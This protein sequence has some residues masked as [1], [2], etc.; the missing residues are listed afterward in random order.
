MKSMTQPVAGYQPN[1]SKIRAVNI[2][3]EK[4]TGGPH[5]EK[6]EIPLHP[7]AQR[8]ELKPLHGKF[9]VPRPKPVPRPKSSSAPSKGDHSVSEHIHTA[10]QE[11][12]EDPSFTPQ[13]K[14]RKVEIQVNDDY[15]VKYL[16]ISPT[17][18]EK[19]IGQIHQDELRQA[20]HALAAM[21]TT[22]ST[23]DGGSAGPSVIP[24]AAPSN[25]PSTAPTK[26]F[27]VHL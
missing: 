1:R 19:V 9:S 14:S 24:S 18:E 3:L 10:T 6:F 16:S 23:T 20:F 22:Q 2:P 25:A 5:F 13:K 4:Q 15:K 26:S 17:K 21:L 11:T 12:V 27:Q 7:E 8:E